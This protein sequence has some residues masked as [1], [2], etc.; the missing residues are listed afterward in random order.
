[1]DSD[2]N[3]HDDE[4]NTYTY[5]VACSNNSL[6]YCFLS[7]VCVACQGT[8]RTAED[9]VN[10]GL[11]LLEQVLVGCQWY[12]PMTIFVHSRLT[13]KHNAKTK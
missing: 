3:D 2:G 6:L 4:V 1:M 12:I 11:D 9:K 8:A 7:R 13:Y 10:D 5:Y